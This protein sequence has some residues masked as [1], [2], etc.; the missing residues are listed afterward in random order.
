MLDALDVLRRADP[1]QLN[2]ISYYVDHLGVVHQ[3]RVFLVQLK[4]IVVGVQP[5]KQLR[6]TLILWWGL[7]ILLL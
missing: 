1:F 4:Q 3:Q 5:F 6:L 7:H 2:R